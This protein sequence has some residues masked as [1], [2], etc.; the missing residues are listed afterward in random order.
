[1]E[2]NTLKLIPNY[3]EN[4]LEIKIPMAT[5]LNGIVVSHWICFDVAKNIFF[6]SDF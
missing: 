4:D 2:I 3:D 5:I 6:F 1:M